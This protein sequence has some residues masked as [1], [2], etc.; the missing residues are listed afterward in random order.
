VLKGTTETDVKNRDH[1][2]NAC[3]AWNLQLVGW[4]G[5]TLVGLTMIGSFVMAFVH[6][7]TPDV[8]A[9][10]KAARAGHRKR[11]E[12]AVTPVISPDGGGATLR[13]DW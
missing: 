13:F 3:S 11:R 1:F 2:S 7:E 12:L 4:G 6:E 8:P 9:D 5:I 10:T